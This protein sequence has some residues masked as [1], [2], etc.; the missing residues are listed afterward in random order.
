MWISRQTVKSDS[1]PP[2]QS[3]V[4]T[5]NSDGEIEA[6][7]TGTERSVKIYSPYGYSFSV[8][9]GSE[10]LLSRSCGEQVSFGTQMN[11]DGVSEGEIKITSAAGGYIYLKKDGSVI[12]NG[13]KI[14]S[15]GVIE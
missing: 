2:V 15:K 14:N 8:P 4:V 7:S 5:L 10:L 9:T 1:E 13:L 3:G 12:I 6:V 11:S